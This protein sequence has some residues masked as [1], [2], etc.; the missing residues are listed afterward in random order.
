M[1]TSV[2]VGTVPSAV[3]SCRALWSVHVPVDHAQIIHVTIKNILT[4]FEGNFT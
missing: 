2:H 1:V 3:G 4:V